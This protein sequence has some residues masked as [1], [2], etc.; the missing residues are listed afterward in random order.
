MLITRRM[1]YGMRI[2]LTLALRP[3]ERVRGADLAK[4]IQAPRHFVLKVVNA[5]NQAGLV[6][7]RRGVGGGVELAKPAEQISALD[8]LRAT[9]SP[10]AI[11][12]CLTNPLACG[13]SKR[14]AV[15]RLLGEI[16]E[17]ID[18]KFRGLSLADIAQEQRA[19]DEETARAR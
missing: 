19:I 10:R 9:D 5:L 3:D 7:A 14:C 8:V 15:H 12:V 11:N 13:R 18:D 16:Q 4:E 17:T 6:I 2:M 1:D